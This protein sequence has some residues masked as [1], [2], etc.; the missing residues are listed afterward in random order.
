V[1][2]LIPLKQSNHSLYLEGLLERPCYSIE[3]P[4]TPLV[5]SRNDTL[6]Y[7]KRTLKG[8]IANGTFCLIVLLYLN[9]LVIIVR[10]RTRVYKSSPLVLLS[11]F[12]III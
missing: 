6:A 3:T 8:T 7:A 11:L 10:A 2:L 12:E 1:Q 4:R 9:S 5:R